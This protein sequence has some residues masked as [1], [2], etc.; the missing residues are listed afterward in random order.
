GIDTDGEP[1]LT[2]AGPEPEKAKFLVE[3]R[4]VV[5]RPVIRRLHVEPAQRWSAERTDEG[6]LVQM[7]QPNLKRLHATHGQ[8]SQSAVFS[9]GARAV[10]RIDLWDE[11]TGEHL[12]ERTEVEHPSRLANPVGV[13]VVHDDDHG[14]RLLGG[15]QIV[16]NEIG[17]TL[18]R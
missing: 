9:V 4:G 3:S 11:F 6:E 14:L 12:L 15:N 17:P 2:G 18:S 13:A 7:V 1:L 16:E 10:G 5:E 8:S